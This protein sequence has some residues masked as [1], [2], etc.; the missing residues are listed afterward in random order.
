VNR[1]LPQQNLPLRTCLVTGG[2]GFIGSHLVERLLSLGWQV[3]IV[4]D[5]ST[6][7]RENLS[8]LSEYELIEGDIKDEACIKKCLQD[9]DVVF[10]LAARTSVPRSIKEPTK[11]NLINSTAS[12]LLARLSAERGIKILVYSSSSSIYGEKRNPKKSEMMRPEPKSPYAVSKLSGERYCLLYGYISP[13]Y[14]VALR[15]FNVFGPRQDPH[16]PYSA[17][18][19]RFIQAL[20]N[21][22]RPTIYGDGEQSRDFTY[23][24]NVVS[25]NLLALSSSAVKPTVF[26]IGMGRRTTINQLLGLINT[27]FPSLYRKEPINEP[28]RQGDVRH[29]QANIHKAQIH[30]GYHPQVSLKEGLDRTVKWFQNQR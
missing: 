29:S 11:T 9:I 28:P 20:F 24:D 26:N 6:G 30:L 16:S 18:I 2:A 22:E 4:D 7:K 3:R 27:N 15:Y 14:V 25:A 8:H 10:H 1:R 23:V 13:M 5:F 17:V 19:P 21:G 12:L